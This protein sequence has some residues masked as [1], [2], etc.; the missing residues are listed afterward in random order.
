MIFEHTEH[1]TT[2]NIYAH[3][4]QVVTKQQCYLKNRADSKEL[5]AKLDITPFRL[6]Q[7]S[8]EIGQCPILVSF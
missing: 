6:S 3:K 2:Q 8:F 7:E 4:R 5:N 1:G